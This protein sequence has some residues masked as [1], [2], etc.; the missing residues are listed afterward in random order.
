MIVNLTECETKEISQRL[1]SIEINSLWPEIFVPQIRVLRRDHKK[2]NA[3]I[4]IFAFRWLPTFLATTGLFT[5]DEWR[6]QFRAG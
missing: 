5:R 3:N 2:R 1:L 6:N 4:V